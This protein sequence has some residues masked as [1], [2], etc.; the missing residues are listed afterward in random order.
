MTEY[1]LP[2]C[3][4]DNYNEV[5]VVSKTVISFVKLKDRKFIFNPTNP[6]DIGMFNIKGYLTDS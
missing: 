1:E 4:D 5:Q 3:L 2:E 6:F